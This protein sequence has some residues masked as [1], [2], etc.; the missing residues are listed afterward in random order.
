MNST[1]ESHQFENRKAFRIWLGVNYRSSDGIWIIFTKGNKNFTSNDALEES[2]CFGWID[3]VMKSIDDTKYK[4]YFSRRIDK[5]KWSE[6][7]REI[8]KRLKDKGLITEF[9]IDAYQ[10]N[11]KN[12]EVVDK[13]SMHANNIEKLK[14][15]LSMESDISKLFEN[16]I[17]SRQKQ[18][19]GFYCEAK[20]EK[21]RKR[22]KEKII[23]AIMNNYKGMLY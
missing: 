9:G 18:L 14:D 10:D 7:N 22:R 19:A 6:K 2:I 1:A 23:E 17:R 12:N 11:D 5:K 16:T 3:G 21:T 4:K 20:T 13:N 8:Y 15:A